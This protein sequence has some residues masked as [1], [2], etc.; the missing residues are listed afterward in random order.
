MLPPTLWSCLQSR[1]SVCLY[2][3]TFKSLTSKVKAILLLLLLLYYDHY[4]V[5]ESDCL[6]ATTSLSSVCEAC[7]EPPAA[8]VDVLVLM[9]AGDMVDTRLLMSSR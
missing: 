3:L 4:S 9:L 7:R 5:L 6:T 2:A 1:L 8:P